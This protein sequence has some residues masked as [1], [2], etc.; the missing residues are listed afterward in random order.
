MARDKHIPLSAPGEA[1]AVR[2][3]ISTHGRGLE[4]LTAATQSLGERSGFRLKGRL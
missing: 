1:H 3:G 4:S 2:C